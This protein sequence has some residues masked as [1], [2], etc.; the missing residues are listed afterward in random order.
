MNH[1]N[2]QDDVMFALALVYIASKVMY[3]GK[4]KC[5]QFILDK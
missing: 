5:L 3:V 1:H 2:M 4:L